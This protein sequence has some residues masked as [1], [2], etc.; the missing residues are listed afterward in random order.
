MSGGSSNPYEAYASS[1]TRYDQQRYQSLV[2]VNDL[3]LADRVASW[4]LAVAWSDPSGA[5]YEKP[6]AKEPRDYKAVDSNYTMPDVL[7]TAT[8]PGDNAPNRGVLN[9]FNRAKVPF[10]ITP[11]L[12]GETDYEVKVA[13]FQDRMRNL[14]QLDINLDCVAAAFDGEWWYVAA[15]GELI[16]WQ[17]VQKL[18]AELGGARIILV[19][20]SDRNLHAEM[21][22]MSYL[23]ENRLIKWG[24]LMGVSKP[25]CPNCREQLDI[26]KVRYTSYHTQAPQVGRWTNPNL[27]CPS[28]Y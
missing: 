28:A 25:C 18:K 11:P 23:K 8:P 15:N 26:W 7:K 22:I 1:D 12:A 21:K 17:H 13:A 27:G 9:A 16:S 10:N 4:L 19:E 14:R 24:I 3:A 5:E 6:P 20:G 2:Q